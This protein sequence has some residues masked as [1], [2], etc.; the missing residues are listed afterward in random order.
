[1]PW[2]AL[3]L[4]TASL[5]SLLAAAYCIPIFCA[6]VI[7]TETFRRSGNKSSSFG[8]NILG[9]VAGGLTQNA[10]FLIGL[11]ALLLLAAAFYSLAGI[12]AALEKGRAPQ[13]IVVSPTA[14]V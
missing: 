14:S 12:F 13:S 9:A 6:G 5:G 10:S 7:F 8:S 2:E 1:M 4:G 3:P 11:N